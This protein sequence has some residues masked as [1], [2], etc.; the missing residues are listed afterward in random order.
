MS[1]LSG[2]DRHPGSPW[3]FY[4]AHRYTILFYSLLFTTLAGPLSAT[5][6]IDDRA[7]EVALGLNLLAAVL[8]M[9][10]S[11]KTMLLLS[12]L[13]LAALLARIAVLWLD[14][15]IFP[16]MSLGFWSLLALTAAAN[17][18]VFALRAPVID[19]E[20]VYAALS[21]YVL[22][23]VFFGV[24]YWVVEQFQSGSFVL[25]G[26]LSRTSAIY[27][28]F[29]TLATLG[30]GDISPRT[31][32]ARGLAIIEG[33]GGQLFLAVFVARLISLYAQHKDRA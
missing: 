25:A 7:I 8:P 11:S 21:A 9:G 5:L 17:A 4:L 12:G 26:E 33:V 14:R 20:H 19:H 30:Y 29:V 6:G 10:E 1:S 27:F 31:D 2:I 13:V 3:Q 24:L 28:S 18:L 32:L 15:G 23:G 16:A 22:V